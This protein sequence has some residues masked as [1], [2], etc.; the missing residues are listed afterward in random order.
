MRDY[1]SAENKIK[2]AL[3]SVPERFLLVDTSKQRLSVIESGALVKEYP[4]STSK[5]GTGNNEGSF[6]TPRGVHRVREKYGHGAPAGRV[7]RD[8]LDTG[9]DWPVGAPGGNVIL[10]RILRLEG[11][12][13]GVNRGSGIDSYE[14]YI[15]IHGTNNE[16]AVGSPASHGCVC[17]KNSDVID[18][19]DI[20]PEGT[21]VLI[22]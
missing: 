11:C 10:S 7:F 14:R 13:E 1:S 12:E 21:V 16:A 18:L 5:F 4:V 15:Y 2:R 17:M 19:F 6:K 8:R 9:E 22:D 3:G 20:V